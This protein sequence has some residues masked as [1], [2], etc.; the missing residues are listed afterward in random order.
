MNGYDGQDWQLNLA[1]RIE[2]LFVGNVRADTSLG[3]A[4]R[5]S[6]DE[7]DVLCA[8]VWLVMQGRLRLLEEGALL[9][10]LTPAYSRE[11]ELAA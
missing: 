3:I 4:A 11:L 9:V 2:Q 6:A 7:D 1:E 10:F 8:L 5:L